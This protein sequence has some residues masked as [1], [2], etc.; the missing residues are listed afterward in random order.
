M[1]VK[2]NGS[3]EVKIKIEQEIET[4]RIEL[5]EIANA[6]MFAEPEDFKAHQDKYLRLYER[7]NGLKTTLGFV[8]EF[9][10]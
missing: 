8:K 5:D 2:T 10:Q 9:G 7:L 3:L 1:N 6:A 4:T